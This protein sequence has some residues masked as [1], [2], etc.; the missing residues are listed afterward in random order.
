MLGCAIDE[1]QLRRSAQ[2]DS[3]TTDDCQYVGDDD[4]LQKK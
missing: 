1:Q 2:A 4:S 3:A